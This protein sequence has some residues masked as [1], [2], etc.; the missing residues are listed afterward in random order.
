MT[1]AEGYT[2]RQQPNYC[3]ETI[4]LYQLVL[5]KSLSIDRPLEWYPGWHNIINLSI[6]LYVIVKTLG[7]I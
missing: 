7:P 5:A 2:V 3:D 4:T 1:T 6:Q